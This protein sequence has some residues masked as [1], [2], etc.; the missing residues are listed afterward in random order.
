MAKNPKALIPRLT[1]TGPNRVVRGDLGSAGT[2]G[3]VFSPASGSN[4][5]AVVFAHDWVTHPRRYQRTLRHLASWGF[6]VAAPSTGRGFFASDKEFAAELARTLEILR[7]AT[8]GAGRVQTNPERI[9]L[10]GHGFGASA[11]V[12]A[13]AKEPGLAGVAALWPSKTTAV[14]A[15]AA[16]EIP[17]PGLIL[18]TVA[19]ELSLTSNA[20][21]LALAW[22]GE[23]ALRAIPAF[24]PQRLPERLGPRGWFEFDLAAGRNG[25]HALLTGWLLAVLAKDKDY[26]A[27][28]NPEAELPGV[29]PLDASAIERN[30][31]SA[32]RALLG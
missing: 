2:P 28:A 25:V 11:A 24:E 8:F 21:E 31:V 23:A 18:A 4:A 22:G 16:E 10:V 3:L 20:T 30:P 26:A 17:A 12:L 6:V 27:F 14:V 5:P 1:R 19:E 29:A 9:G 32:V 7:T 15:Q 13:A